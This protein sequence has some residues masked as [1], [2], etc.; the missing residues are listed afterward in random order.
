MHKVIICGVDTSKLPQLK[1]DEQ[2]R[3]LVLIKRDNDKEAREKFVMA[4]LRLVLSLVQRFDSKYDSNDLFQVGTVGLLKALNNFDMSYNVK[5][6]TYAVPMILGEIRKFVK[7]STSI[8]VSRSMRDTAYLALKAREEI[9]IK[10]QKTATISEIAEYIDKPIS[11][12]ACALNAISEP[13]SIYDTVYSDDEDSLSL[14]DQLSDERETEERWT[15]NIALK[16]SFQ[17]LSE[18]EKLVLLLRYFKDKTQV[19]IAEIIG[20]S[21][22]QVSRLEK[23][24]LSKMKTYFV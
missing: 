2:D 4:N 8:K 20:V 19:E 3:L 14:M 6:S 5:F 9:E 13:V 7:E 22:A 24:A 23:I 11:E 16:E 12:V 10:E 1:A 21:Q 18:K 17:S 15:D